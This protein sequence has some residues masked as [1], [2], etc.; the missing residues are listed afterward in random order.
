[1]EMKYKIIQKAGISNVNDLIA[2][3]ATDSEF[4]NKFT[5]SK[6]FIEK[7]KLSEKEVAKIL[8]FNHGPKRNEAISMGP[9]RT[10]RYSW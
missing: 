4:K 10:R 6:L 5:I 8:E 7:Y 9:P 2:K 3:I 1:M